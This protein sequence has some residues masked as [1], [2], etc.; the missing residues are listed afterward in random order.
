MSTI[1]DSIAADPFLQKAREELD[2][3]NTQIAAITRLNVQ[4]IED[5]V[6]KD[7]LIS[8]WGTLH[9]QYS[10]AIRTILNGATA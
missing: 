10:G 4:T 5:K 3:L 6:R 1:Y 7:A 8:R 2:A 9:S